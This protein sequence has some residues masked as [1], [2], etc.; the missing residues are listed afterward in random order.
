MKNE[1]KISKCG[2]I[3]YETMLHKRANNIKITGHCNAFV[4]NHSPY[5]TF[6]YNR[7][8]NVQC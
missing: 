8:R 7:H 4:K 5:P 2:I 3:A 6:S 1:Y